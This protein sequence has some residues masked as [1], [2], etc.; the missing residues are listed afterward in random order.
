MVGPLVLQ[1]DGRDSQAAIGEN[2]CGGEVG[3]GGGGGGG[4]EGGGV[5]GGE[6]EMSNVCT[7]AFEATYNI[8]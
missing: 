6:G 5:R 7:D 8:I 2:L 3:G 1:P 4:G